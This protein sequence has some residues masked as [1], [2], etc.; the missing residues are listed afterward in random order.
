MR[1]LVYLLMATAMVLAWGALLVVLARRFLPSI[2]E[3]R[4]E[5]RTSTGSPNER[6]K[7]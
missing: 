5:A 3:L 7:K 1:Y 2:P 4:T 6:T